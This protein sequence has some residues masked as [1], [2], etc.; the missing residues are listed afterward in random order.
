MEVPS[1]VDVNESTVGN[2]YVYPYVVNSM[3]SKDLYKI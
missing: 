1:L 3:Y 2:I